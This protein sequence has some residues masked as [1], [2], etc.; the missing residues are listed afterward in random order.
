[1]TL[2]PG[3]ISAVRR[4]RIPWLVAVPLMVAGSVSAHGLAYRIVQPN[5]D[6]R[7]ALLHETGHGYL[8]YLPLALGIL[9][10][11]LVAGLVLRAAAAVRGRTSVT[12]SSWSFFLL[13]LAGFAVQEHLE[14]LIHDGSFPVDA[15]TQPT[16]LIGLAL[17][18]P[19]ALAAFT[20]AW[21]LLEVAAR[22]G[23]TLAA[24][25]P[26][27]IKRQTVRMPAIAGVDVLRPPCLALGYTE[28]GPPLL[29]A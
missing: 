19:F 23:R 26:L 12:L 24:R 15:V 28:R 9:V 7:A 6:L 8:D 10:A 14:R 3:I 16:F 22:V 25:P 5:P 20:V 18:L 21:T 1:M 13:P 17:Q 2:A 29:S 4:S 11:L 27:G